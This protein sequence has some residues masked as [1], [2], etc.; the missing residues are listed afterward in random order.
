M[1]K[2]VD[3]IRNLVDSAGKLPKVTWNVARPGGRDPVGARVRAQ[4][5]RAGRGADTGAEGLDPRIGAGQI[6][7]GISIGA[8][9]GFWHEKMDEWS[10]AKAARPPAA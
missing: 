7:T 5:A 1:T 4:P 10:A 8:M 3:T 6:L 2:I 9:A